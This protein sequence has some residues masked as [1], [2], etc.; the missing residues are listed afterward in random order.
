MPQRARNTA[1]QIAC[2]LVLSLIVVGCNLKSVTYSGPYYQGD[3]NHGAMGWRYEPI[4]EWVRSP[5]ALAGRIRLYGDVNGYA[6]RAVCERL[7]IL[8]EMDNVERI[9]IY[10]NSKGG[11]VDGYLPIINTI[12][13]MSKPVD[14]VNHGFCVSAACIVHQSATG[15]RLASRNAIFGLHALRSAS[16]GSDELRALQQSRYTETIRKRSNLPSDWFPLSSELIHFSTE[17]ALQYEFID[18]V[19]E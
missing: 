3:H 1:M 7:D 16:H 5:A 10:I 17:E 8:A 11:S 9:T 4:A 18:D 19:I 15:N 2:C 12:N 13:L 14:T 6:A